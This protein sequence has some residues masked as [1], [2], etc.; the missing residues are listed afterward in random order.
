MTIEVKKRLV[1]VV[2]LAFG[3]VACE[4][5]KKAIEGAPSAARVAKAQADAQA[6]ASA[7][8]VYMATCG[9]QLPASLEE[10]TTTKGV[11]GLACGPFLKAVP[12]APD[13]FTAYEYAKQADGS[14]TV[15]TSGGGVTVKAQ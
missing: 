12:A 9:G 1:V 6:I 14:F 5:E 3:L 11:G 2:A 8:R 7:I 15:T 4:Q 10:L 13:G